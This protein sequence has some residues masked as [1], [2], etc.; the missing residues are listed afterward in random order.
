M[1]VVHFSSPAKRDKR[2][3]NEDLAQQAEEAAGKK[4]KQPQGTLPNYQKGR[5]ARWDPCRGLAGWHWNL[6]HHAILLIKNI[7]E[8]G[9][10]PTDCRD[11]LI[12]IIPRKGDLRD[13][14]NYQGIMLLSTPGKVFNRIILER[15]WEGVDEKSSVPDFLYLLSKYELISPTKTWWVIQFSSPAY[16]PCSQWR[17]GIVWRSLCQTSEAWESQ[18]TPVSHGHCPQRN[19]GL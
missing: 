1:W 7:W 13:C 10:M 12:A 9:N 5:R 2:N 4:E 14:N 18:W 3:Y 11:G 8:K 6:N 16:R 17:P 19:A 15:L